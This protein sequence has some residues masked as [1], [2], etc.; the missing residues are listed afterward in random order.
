MWRR[1]SRP[2]FLIFLDASLETIAR[3]RAIAWGQDRLDALQGRLAHARQHCD[4]Y[5]DTDEMT[6]EEVTEYVERA[7]FAAGIQPKP[8]Q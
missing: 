7:L 2:H 4:L 5:V 1:L 8:S 6:P 3:R